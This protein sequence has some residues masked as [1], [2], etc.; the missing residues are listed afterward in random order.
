MERCPQA[1]WRRECVGGSSGSRAGRRRVPESDPVQSEVV[2]MIRGDQSAD[3]LTSA[4]RKRLLSHVPPRNVL[5]ER[6]SPPR[7]SITP[8][9]M[10]LAPETLSTEKE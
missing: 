6:F 9:P 2:S 4:L 3:T 7:P 5:T 8:S 10:M 1:G